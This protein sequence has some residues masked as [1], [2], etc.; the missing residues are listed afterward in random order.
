MDESEQKRMLNTIEN[1]I[2]CIKGKLD[3]LKLEQR[4]AAIFIVVLI[5][6]LQEMSVYTS[7]IAAVVISGIFAFVG[8]S[9]I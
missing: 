1:R 7:F 8:W 5:C 9:R 6:V 2:E 3:E 4:T